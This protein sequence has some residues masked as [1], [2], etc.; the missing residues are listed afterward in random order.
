MSTLVKDSLSIKGGGALGG[1]VKST[2]VRGG[3][4][5]APGGFSGDIFGVAAG[6]GQKSVGK[7]SES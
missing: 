1:T 3:V 2:E 7:M 6:N 4:C 5:G